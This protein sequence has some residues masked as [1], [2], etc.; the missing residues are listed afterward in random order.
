MPDDFASSAF[1][2]VAIAGFFLLGYGLLALV[3]T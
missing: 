2:A 1:L 3:F